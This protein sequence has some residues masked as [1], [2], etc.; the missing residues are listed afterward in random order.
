MLDHASL[1]LEQAQNLIPEGDETTH[2]FAVRRGLLVHQAEF[3]RHKA[4]TT[5]AL[6]VLGKHGGLHN[7]DA[8]I[9]AVLE[10]AGS[11]S[12]VAVLRKGTFGRCCG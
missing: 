9:P 10:Q 7:A 2:A 4:A 1:M 6:A 12:R 8:M 3:V 5:I 11:R